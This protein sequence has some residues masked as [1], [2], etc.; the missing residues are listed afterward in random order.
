M[1]AY[2]KS[3]WPTVKHKTFHIA[4]TQPFYPA[5]TKWNTKEYIWYWTTFLFPFWK[6][7]KMSPRSGGG[8]KFLEQLHFWCQHNFDKCPHFQECITR[9]YHRCTKFFCK[10]IFYEKKSRRKIENQNLIF[11]TGL[12]GVWEERD[13]F[14]LFTVK[15]KQG[16]AATPDLSSKFEIKS[17]AYNDVWIEVLK[18]KS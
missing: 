10:I 15:I 12:N 18:K 2:Q 14:P 6:S 11:F 3:F 7:R 17:R 5:S 13:H 16:S 9:N 4:P 8:S 1:S